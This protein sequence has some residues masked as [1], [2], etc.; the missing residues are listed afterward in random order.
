MKKIIYFIIFLLYVTPAYTTNTKTN[1]NSIF[2]KNIHRLIKQH[3]IRSSDLSLVIKDISTGHFNYAL[4]GE[5]P[6]IPASLTKILIAGAVLNTFDPGHTFETQ[7]LIKNKIKEGLLQ[8]PLYLKGFGDPSFTSEKMWYLVNELMRKQISQIQGDIII[9][10]SLFDSIRRDPHRLPQP[11]DRAYDAPIGALSFNWNAIN[12]FLSPGP[13]KNAPA[14]IYL[15]PI[16]EPIQLINK[17]KTKG[18]RL[19]AT[20]RTA[21]LSQP[22][23]KI[24]LVEVSGSIPLGHK[25]KAY[26]RKINHPDLWTGAN[27]KAFL[28]QRGVHVQG[29]IKKGQVP[30]D[31]QVVASSSGETVSE[32][33]RLMMKYSNN[34]IAEMLTNQLA[35]VAGSQVGNLSDG[36]RVVHSHIQSLGFSSK[37]FITSNAAGLSRQNRLKAHSLVKLL[38]IYH[39]HFSSSYEF[40]SS[41]PIA[42]QDGTL[43]NRMKSAK[44]QVRAKSGQLDGVIG[45]A[46]YVQTQNQ[47]IKT[48]AVIYNGK[49]PNHKVIQ[50]IDQLILSLYSL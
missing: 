41:L 45:L 37:D 20:I 36:L 9:D 23:E 2:Q 31:A 43:K 12:I 47:G 27:L 35:L 50:F 18:R 28:K 6:R 19:K 4:H 48:F 15:D 24:N 5:I 46:G 21:T 26:Y 34:F 16:D 49:K 38:Q 10:D 39:S 13:K 17:I 32:L 40:I 33:I 11:T 29:Q 42:G 3:R 44:G 25:E 8:G 7:L 1:T 14:F 22:S 30:S